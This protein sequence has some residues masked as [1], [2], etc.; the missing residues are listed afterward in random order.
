MTIGWLYTWLMFEYWWCM[1]VQ[2]NV[3]SDLWYVQRLSPDVVMYVNWRVT[4][5][6]YASLTYPRFVFQFLSLLLQNYPDCKKGSREV[7]LKAAVRAMLSHT[8]T[9][10]PVCVCVWVDSAT[11]RTSNLITKHGTQ[12]RK[13]Y[14]HSTERDE[15]RHFKRNYSRGTGKVK[16]C[17]G[18]DL[19][20]KA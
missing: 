2:E 3:E 6:L 4:W 9:C 1:L 11:T 10:L 19:F 13:N 7:R 5:V 15:Y 12:W 17:V 14:R 20:T 8:G 18:W 16:G